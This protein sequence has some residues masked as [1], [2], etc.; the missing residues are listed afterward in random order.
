VFGLC[1]IT[2]RASSHGLSESEV[3]RLAY[4]GGADIVQLRMKTECGKEM[5]EQAII[6]KKYALMYHRLFIVN[7]RVDIALLSDADGVHLGQMDFSI[8]DARKLLGD[9]KII[10]KSVHNIEEALA[11]VDEGVDY[12]GVGSVFT[13]TTKKDAKQSLGLETLASIKNAVDIP[14]VAI[15]GIDKDNILSVIA[16]GI[17]AVAVVSAVVSENDI[18]KT[19]REMR[20]L[21]T[22]KK[23]KSQN[24]HNGDCSEDQ[25]K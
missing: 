19:T 10:G 5:L 6:I 3:A 8:K 4:L 24:I 11:A 22:T 25:R 2:D 9:S 21:I 13:T 20:A 1:V 14:V 7:D 23:Q 17:E 12:L 15:G 16:T 18:T